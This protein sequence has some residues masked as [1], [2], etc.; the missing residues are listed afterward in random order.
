MSQKKYKSVTKKITSHRTDIPVV[1]GEIHGKILQ[2][3]GLS[4]GSA[5]SKR[6]GDMKSNESS[7]RVQLRSQLS[8][9]HSGT[10]LRQSEQES[11]QGADSSIYK[12]VKY[13][14]N[15]TDE[16][17]MLLDQSCN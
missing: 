13:G 11:K 10:T 17:S 3:I 2:S 16:N 15:K 9:K 5:V 14:S 4:Q 8:A 6:N 7:V 12:R 1:R